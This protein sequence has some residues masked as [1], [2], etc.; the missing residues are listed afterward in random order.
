VGT[1]PAEA[2]TEPIIP[3]VEVLP[4]ASVPADEK[5]PPHRIGP[6]PQPLTTPPVGAPIILPPD[7][8]AMLEVPPAH[9]ELPPATQRMLQ[10]RRRAALLAFLGIAA[11]VL[12]VGQV[13]R[14]NDH[15]PK[16][17]T[18]APAASALPPAFG[19][20]AGIGEPTGAPSRSPSSD[21]AGDETKTAPA[22]TAPADAANAIPSRAG[23]TTQPTSAFTFVDGYGPVLGTAGTL[24]RFKVAVER[25]LGQGNGADFADEVDRDLGDER[26]WIASRQFRLQRVPAAAASEFTIYL[27]SADTSEKMCAAGG[28]STDGFTSC[29]LPGQVIINNDRWQDAVAGYDAPLETY[30][31]YAINHEVGHQL[32]YGH[33]GCPGKGQPAPV[34]MQQTYGLKGCVANAWPYID[35]KRYTGPPI[36]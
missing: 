10:R 32:G 9:P 33:E 24:R 28:L 6:P 20:G 30:R 18:I 7:A 2:V 36:P 13:V 5:A 12:L 1:T 35:G 23:A 4:P 31:A 14:S 8:D 11:A 29:R 26:S 25:T 34:M 17:T 22:R 19:P 21:D 16:S 27:V 3:V 15:S